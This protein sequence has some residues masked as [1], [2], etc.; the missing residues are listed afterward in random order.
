MPTWREQGAQHLQCSYDTVCLSSC[1]DSKKNPPD[2]LCEV[3]KRERM[4]HVSSDLGA[5][6]KNSHGRALMSP[7][8]DLDCSV[9]SEELQE[10]T[11]SLFSPPIRLQS[12][13]FF[14]HSVLLSVKTTWQLEMFVWRRSAAVAFGSRR[15]WA[16][17]KTLWRRLFPLPSKQE[18]R[19]ITFAIVVF[20][21]VFLCSEFVFRWIIQFFLRAS[22]VNGALMAV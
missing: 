8:L 4:W 3:N 12:F 10:R 18:T 5:L 22:N 17:A 14:P 11:K 16:A 1:L 21:G 19:K 13:F 15:L 6:W 9:K 7:L 20:L 2:S